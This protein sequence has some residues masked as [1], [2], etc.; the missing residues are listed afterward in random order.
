M[1]KDRMSKKGCFARE[2]IQSAIVTCLCLLLV[3]IFATDLHAVKQY[4][5]TASA[6]S[7]GSISPSGAVSVS[8]G[9][10]KTFTIMP[11]TGYHVTNVTVDSVSQGS[12]T[13]YTFSNV[14][15]NHTIAATFAINTYSITG[16]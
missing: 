12:I 13:S 4:T 7:N 2:A 5:I 3:A 10:S 8:S 15:A 14:T 11:N 9:S 1:G 6:G 16:T